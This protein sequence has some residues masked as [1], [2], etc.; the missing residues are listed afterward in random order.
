[1]TISLS[2]HSKRQV[3]KPVMSQR[4]WHVLWQM[5]NWQ[6]HL[7]SNT[8]DCLLPIYVQAQRARSLGAIIYCVGVKDFNQTQVTQHQ[9][10]IRCFSGTSDFN[11][12]FCIGG[13][14]VNL[15]CI[16]CLAGHSCRH[17]RACVPCNWRIPSPW[18]NDRLC[19]FLCFSLC[20]WLCIQV[21]VW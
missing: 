19:E 4:M 11:H 1:M 15:Y 5:C 8:A 18:R 9:C 6:W 7:L 21:K 10:T 17:H 16:T 12:I 14:S 20:P 3:H 2:Q 13:V